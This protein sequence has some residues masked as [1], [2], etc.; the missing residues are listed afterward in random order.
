M[1]VTTP[2]TRPAVLGWASLGWAS[3]GWA[4]LAVVLVLVAYTLIGAPL[5]GQSPDPYV[6]AAASTGLF[7]A[8]F[9]AVLLTRSPRH[10]IGWLFLVVGLTRALAGAAQVWCVSA[11][12]THPGRP[13]GALASWLQLWLPTVGLALAPLIV[14]LFPDG[15]LPGRRWRFVPALSALALVLVAVVLP[16]G[17]WPYRGPRML[18]SAPVPAETAAQVVN[19]LSEIGT[20]LAAVAAVAALAGVLV[21]ARRS[22]GE[23]RQQIK[24]FGLGAVA[25]L[26]ANLIA[27][28]T[29]SGWIILAGIAAS[30][31]GLGAGIFRYRLYDIDRLIRRTLV[32]GTLTVALAGVFAALDVTAAVLTGHGSTVAAAV[33]AFVAALLLQPARGRIQDLVDRLYDRRA[34]NGIRLMRQLGLRVGRDAVEPEQVRDALRTALRDPE[35]DVFYPVRGSIV[36]GAG[37]PADLS[38]RAA[39][40]VRGNGQEI[41]LVVHGPVDANQLAGVLPAAATALAHARLQ[42]E[43]SVQV[44]ALQASRGRIVAAGDAERR[45]IERDLHDGAQQ[46]LVGLAVHIQSARRGVTHPSA[47]DELLSFTVDQL[48]AG[49]DDIRAL[50]HGILPPALV[51]GGLPAALA[52][53]GDVSVAEQPADRPHPDIEATAWFVICEGVANARKHAGGTPIEIAVR[54]RDRRLRVEIADD[55]PGGAREDGDGLRHLAD[56]VEAHGGTLTVHSPPGAGTRLCAELPCG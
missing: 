52:E 32:Y 56:R 27:A 30:F 17:A 14:A 4:S 26:I 40:P 23:V 50:V 15:R 18:P 20:G 41:A 1:P 16:I 31:A 5:D 35:L 43:L 48:R 10:P 34:Y 2:L 22:P 36:D 21:R 8:G 11:L 13:G 7:G 37:R 42:A 49:L 6:Y 54:R 38:G 25:A 12:V 28:A 3:L 39:T 24:W 29:G 46:R 44:A 9:A 47:V 55:G 19:G 45:R 33:A 53:L 51:A